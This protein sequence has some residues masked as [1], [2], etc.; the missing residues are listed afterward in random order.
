MPDNPENTAP[1]GLPEASNGEE[2]I[3]IGVYSC[4]CGGNISDVIDVE[5]LAE[6]LKGQAGVVVSRTD[7]SMCSDAGQ[8][9]I[10][11]DIRK[12][13][14]N[15][16]VIGACKPALHEGTF[17]GAVAR[18][19]LN[20]YLY[21]HVGIRE[22]ASWVH[23]D[24]PAGATAKAQRLMTAGIAKAFGLEPLE[25]IRLDAEKHTLVIGGGIAGLQAALKIAENG[26][27]VTLIEKTPF[28]GGRMAQLESV[29]PT[30]EKARDLLHPL[31][32]QVLAHPAITV[33]TGAELTAV[34]GYVGDFQIEITKTP[35]G[36]PAGFASNQAAI[37]ACPEQVPDEFSYGLMKRKA[38]Y[39]AYPDCR[40]AEAAI[41]WDNCTRCGACQTVP[42]GSGKNGI[43][44]D[45]EPETLALKVGAVVVATGFKPYEPKVGEYGYGES[46]RVI[47]L[48]QLI[49]YAAENG[50][51]DGLMWEG[52]PVKNMAVI[53]C[54]GSRQLEGI[55]EPQEDGILNDYCSR[56]CC[57]ATLHVVSELKDHLPDMNIFDVYED[58]RTYGRGHEEYYIKTSKQLV[59]FL[60]FHGDEPPTMVRGMPGD[61]HP[62]LVQMK[63]YLTWGEEME[64]PVDLV[65]LAVGM[66]PNDVDDLVRL[67]K[68]SRGN[69]RFLLEVHPKLQPVE[70]AV[71][72]VV[73]AGTAQGPMNIQETTSAAMAAAAKVSVLLGKGEVELEPFVARVDLDRCNG[74]GMCVEV[75]CYEDAITLETMLVDGKEVQRA[76]VNPANCA[77]CGVC[78]SACPNRALSVMG[79]T[80]DQYDAMVDAITADLPE[81]EVA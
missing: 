46:S 72:A 28:L 74:S 29:F 16:I 17:R 39:T 69:D 78:V 19:G 33:H 30:G 48:P 20:P 8:A 62:L 5:Q 71:P 64:V 9:M 63:D 49:R 41:D 45:A 6:S 51:K 70:T 14:L 61:N 67:L 58:I 65:V 43:V 22:Q 55:H 81:L 68:I 66:M 13:G 26:I 10:E 77:G 44:L 25:P 2:E 53:H 76:V 59:T 52:K 80:L 42:D 54:I 21:Q 3:R 75:C 50:L 4:Y 12:Y 31:L 27:E 32:D 18:A 37:A 7:M 23:H 73:L 35:R 15:R 60:R 47:T 79:W 56:V 40:P 1:A 38:I 34:K 24:D 57:T 11:E 36:V